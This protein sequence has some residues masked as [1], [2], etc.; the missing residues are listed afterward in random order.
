MAHINDNFILA[1]EELF[2]NPDPRI[3]VVL[4]LDTSSSMSGEPIAELQRGVETFFEAIKSDEVARTSAEIAIVTFD[5]SVRTLL[6]FR[7]IDT[8]EVPTLYANGT[9]SMGEGVLEA[10]RLLEERKTSYQ[11]AGVDYYQPWLVL[12]SDGYPTDDI[13]EA[14]EA[15]TQLAEKRKI[16]VFPIAIG[17]ADTAVLSRLGGGRPALRL[18]GLKFQ[19]FFVWLSKS[20]A[21]VSQ[22][23]PG[24]RINLPEGIDAWAQL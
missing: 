10:L 2:E 7:S 15:I 22:S 5:S 3:P 23:T 17:N 12:M 4:A 14:S 6:D 8:Q 21:R 11:A 24:E 16:S 13:T 18:Q 9:T 20:V 19:E 1:Q